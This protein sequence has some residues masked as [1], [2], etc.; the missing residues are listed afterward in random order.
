MKER[1]KKVDEEKERGR[2]GK[3]EPVKEFR[4]YL[5]AHFLPMRPLPV[6]KVDV[7]LLEKL[8]GPRSLFMRHFRFV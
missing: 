4:Y 2:E 1:G 5:N 7:E 6:F 3:A 8:E